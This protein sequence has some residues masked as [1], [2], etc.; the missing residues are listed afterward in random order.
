M[1]TDEF[2]FF[3]WFAKNDVFIYKKGEGWDI[4]G[5]KK[6]EGGGNLEKIY[7]FLIISCK[8]ILCSD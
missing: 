8:K 6:E 2:F 3:F 4:F 7:F 1:D 5:K